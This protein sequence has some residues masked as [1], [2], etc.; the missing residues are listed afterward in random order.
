MQWQIWTAFGIMLGYVCDLAFFSVPD[1][2]I[3]GLRW[4]LMMASA[5]APAVIV[6][7]FIGCCPESP[8]WYLSRG[9]HAQ[10]YQSMCK[11]RH[12]KIQAARDIFYM[13]MLLHVEGEKV[14]APQNKIVSRPQ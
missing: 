9:K 2:G 1:H 11:L 13:Q 8:R 6:C 7:C 5:M 14:K 12:T 10:A 4:R 3:T